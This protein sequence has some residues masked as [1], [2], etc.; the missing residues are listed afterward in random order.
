MPLDDP[1]VPNGIGSDGALNSGEAQ[2]EA[3]GIKKKWGRRQVVLEPP[4]E[5]LLLSWVHVRFILVHTNL[6]QG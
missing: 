2:G 4:L 3:Q 1:H 5:M 6:E